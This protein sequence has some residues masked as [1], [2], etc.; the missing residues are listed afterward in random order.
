MSSANKTTYRYRSA[1][2]GYFVSEKYAKRHPKTTVREKVAKPGKPGKQKFPKPCGHDFAKYDKKK[3]G[4]CG[5]RR[6]ARMVFA[7][8]P[9]T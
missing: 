5:K 4:I 1:K 6:P 3:C 8:K 7:S 9:G 2:T